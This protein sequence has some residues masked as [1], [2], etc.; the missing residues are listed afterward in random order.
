MEAALGFYVDLLGF[1]IKVNEIE[2]GP[3]IATVTGVPEAVIHIVKAT[4]QDHWMIEL[5]EYKSHPDI[6][7]AMPKL[8][9]I[10]HAHIA[11][12]VDNL[13]AEYER[14]K[15]AGVSFNSVPQPSP[16]GYALVAFCQDPEGNFVELVEVL[17][18]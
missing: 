15:S 10:G 8:R 7:R 17:H 6:P 16:N 18:R 1:Q 11:L 13:S 3:Y 14:L 9:D 4:L 2:R 12:T 5:L